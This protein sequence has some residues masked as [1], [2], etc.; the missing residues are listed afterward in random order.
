MELRSSCVVPHVPV[1]MT[2]L[3]MSRR[4]PEA[5]GHVDPSCQTPLIIDTSIVTACLSRTFSLQL[6][7][8]DVKPFRYGAISQDVWGAL[9][10]GVHPGLWSAQQDSAQRLHL[11]EDRLPEGTAVSCSQCC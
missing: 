11:P 7:T 6:A 2:T 3:A 9:A 5:S 1:Y 4:E 10:E 8:R